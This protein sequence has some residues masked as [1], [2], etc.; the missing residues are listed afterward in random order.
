MNAP[1]T[2]FWIIKAARLFM[3]ALNKTAISFLMGLL[4]ASNIT[5]FVIIS[6]AFL[7]LIPFSTQANR[8]KHDIPLNWLDIAA[9]LIL[10]ITWL[11]AFIMGAGI[12]IGNTFKSQSLIPVAINLLLIVSLYLLN[13]RNRNKDQHNAR[14]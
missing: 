6:V 10:S 9:I 7:L 2:A 13:P 5:L 12:G 8:K 14:L 3:I 1:N 4:L 11:Y